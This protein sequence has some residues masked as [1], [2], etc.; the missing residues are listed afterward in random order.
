MSEE[1]RAALERSLDSLR[2]DIAD[3]RGELAFSDVMEGAT[4][5]ETRLPEIQAELQRLRARGYAFRDDLEPG[6]EA[7]AAKIGPLV[8]T[9]REEIER[10]QR[11]LRR[12]AQDLSGDAGRITGNLLRQEGRIRALEGRLKSLKSEVEETQERLEAQAEPVVSAITSTAD[13]TRDLHW[14]LDQFEEATFKLRPEERPVAVAKATWTD[15]PGGEEAEGLLLFTDHRVYFEHKEERVTKRKFIFF[16]AETETIHKKLIDEP[17]GHLTASDDSTKGWIIADQLLTFG[18]SDAADAPRKT[19]F[20]LSG[21]SAKDWDEVVELIRS[22][23][24]S[25]YT[26]AD[27]SSASSDVV[28]GAPPAGAAH[29]TRWPEHCTACSAPLTPPVKGQTSI[30][31]SYCGTAHAVEFVQG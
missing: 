9:L 1:K 30:A 27:A 31:C 19:T 24:L 23:D 26:S 18:W 25:R 28:A 22:G 5:A 21:G 2:D 15:P 14:T 7:A 11:H 16:T 17:I 6:L 13:K 4:G 20:K 10:A 8:E 29:Q 3:M 12:E